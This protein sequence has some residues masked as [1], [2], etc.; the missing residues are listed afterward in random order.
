MAVDRLQRGRLRPPLHDRKWRFSAAVAL[1]D[2]PGAL[3][4]VQPGPGSECD[5]QRDHHGAFDQ[6]F[7]VPGSRNDKGA[8]VLVHPGKLS[9]GDGELKSLRRRAVPACVLSL[10]LALASAQGSPAAGFSFGATL[11]S[12]SS[13]RHVPLPLLQ[14]ITYVTVRWEPINQAAAD[15]GIGPMHIPPSRMTQAAALSGHTAAQAT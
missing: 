13:A 10:V 3:D 5:L 11:Q 7:D 9:R 14:A 12:V 1:A 8:S 6:G 15:G 2:E 4:S